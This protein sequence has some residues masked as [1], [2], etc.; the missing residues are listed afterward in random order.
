MSRR[1]ND[2]SLEKDFDNFEIIKK[3]KKEET[4]WVNKKKKSKKK[5]INLKNKREHK[6]GIFFNE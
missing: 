2:F 1:I 6:N 5:D 3:R 4:E